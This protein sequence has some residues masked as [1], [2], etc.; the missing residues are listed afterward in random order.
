MQIYSTD[1]GSVFGNVTSLSSYVMI[2][3]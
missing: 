2:H 1:D 3:K